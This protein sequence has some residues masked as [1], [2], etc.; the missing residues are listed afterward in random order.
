ME[1][2]LLAFHLLVA[3]AWT[4][5]EIHPAEALVLGQYLLRLPLDPEQRRR[6]QEYLSLRPAADFSRLWLAQVIEAKC[7]PDECRELVEALRL[8]VAADGRVEAHEQALLS[9]LEQALREN[10]PESLLKRFK[11]WL[12]RLTGGEPSTSPP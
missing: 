3:A 1:K 6:E 11:N 5:G 9:D 12:R 8:V 2:P 4:D 10:E 7:A